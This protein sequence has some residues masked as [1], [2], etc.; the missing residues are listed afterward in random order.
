MT[1]AKKLGPFLSTML[2]T[3][4]TVGSAVYLLPASLG[5]FGSIS[6]LGWLVASLAAVFIGAVFALLALANPGASGLFSYVRD[7][8]GPCAGFVCAFLYWA[9]CLVAIVA[10]AL[11]V[12]GY[13]SFFIP[14]ATKPPGLA[15]A[16]IAVIWVFIAANIL[17]PRFIA[18]LQSWAVFVGLAPVLFAMVGGWF[19][20][21]GATFASS[22]NV[23]G[24]SDLAILPRSSVIA[25]WGFLGIEAAIILSVR[26]RNPSRDVVVGT[27]CGIAISTIIYVA[28]SAALMGILPAA[29]LAKSS[30]P[31]ADAFLPAL[32]ASFAGAVALC[33]MLKASGTLASTLLLTV[34]TA[35]CDAI[36]GR[37]RATQPASVA[38]RA[39][40][41]NMIFTGLVTSVLVALSISPTL[42]RQY[43][44][45]TNASVVLS[46]V[47][48]LASGLALLRLRQALPRRLRNWSWVAALSCSLICVGLIAASEE[49]S[50][51]GSAAMFAV[52]LT[53]Y[54]VLHLRSQRRARLAQA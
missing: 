53:V 49:A 34:E 38:P 43:T 16:T 21:H 14:L 13:L 23:S 11:A 47:V 17:G 30:A 44:I 36:L 45:V 26:V 33:A 12:A 37:L 15:V 39:S 52:A 20:F 51:I 22:W 8:F 19:Y 4:T 46:L 41:R 48:Y 18:H 5:L 28:S 6:I 7:A 54:F 25:F 27:L 32:G 24:Q 42:A 29:M 2:V 1:D 35:E 9:S 40:I 3:S 10:I 50:L 31:Y